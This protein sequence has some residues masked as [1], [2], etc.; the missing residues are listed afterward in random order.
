M[1][2]APEHLAAAQSGVGR[3]LLCGASLADSW[4]SYQ[5]DHTALA[6]ERVLQRR[7]ELSHL[8]LPPHEHA[9]RKGVQHVCFI[10]GTR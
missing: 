8:G 3:E 5:G 6:A 7:L 1:A 9:T 4:L 10:L 2:A